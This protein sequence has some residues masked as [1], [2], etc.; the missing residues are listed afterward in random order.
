MKLKI[1]GIS[2]DEDLKL[3]ATLKLHR[4]TRHLSP[5]ETAALIQQA[6]ISGETISTLSKK[7]NT[8]VDQL[9]KI[10]KLNSLVNDKLKKAIVWGMPGENEISMTVA[11]ELERLKSQTKQLII[12]NNVLKFKLNKHEVTE[13]I[14]LHKRSKK[15]L[16]ECVTQVVKS[17]PQVKETFVITGKIIDKELINKLGEITP[18]DRNKLLKTT[19]E[20]HLPKLSIKGQRLKKKSFVIIGDDKTYDLLTGLDQPYERFVQDCLLKELP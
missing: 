4:K 18:F 3:R 20:K 12:F 5:L 11:K 19:L 1:N 15:S 2:D 8:S 9:R 16:K 14:S 7:L 6:I 13:I 10:H 17:R